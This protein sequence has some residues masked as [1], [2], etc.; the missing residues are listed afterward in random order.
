MA[1]VA[2][3]ETQEMRCKVGPG[4]KYVSC[5]GWIPEF[6]DRVT[7]SG[8]AGDAPFIQTLVPE[9]LSCNGCE[10]QKLGQYQRFVWLRNN[11]TLCPKFW[12]HGSACSLPKET[13]GQAFRM[14]LRY[15]FWHVLRAPEIG[16]VSG[17]N[18]SKLLKGNEVAR[19]I[20]L[21][22]HPISTSQ[23]FEQDFAA[24]LLLGMHGLG[25]VPIPPTL[26]SGWSCSRTPRELMAEAGSTAQA[27]WILA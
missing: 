19:K 12:Q 7:W 6:W 26:P 8:E 24:H 14:K 2:W 3:E 4:T 16:C 22:R 17:H 11:Y 9:K 15:L 20:F 13:K 5:D 10:V 1:S 25:P 18:E 27:F 23:M 21:I